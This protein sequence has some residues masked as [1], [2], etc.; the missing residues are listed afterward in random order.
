MSL[1]DGRV[2]QLL[3]SSGSKLPTLEVVIRDE[4]VAL[5]S[6]IP[7][8]L[9]SG[10]GLEKVVPGGI[11]LDRV[12]TIFGE[13]GSFKSTVKNAIVHAI[14]SA[15]H[16]VVDCSFEDSNAL[17]AARWISRDTGIPYGELAAR[18]RRLVDPQL[19]SAAAA[20][21]VIAAGDMAPTMDEVV[22]V[23]RQYKRIAGAKAVVV[24][25]I[26]LLEGQNQKEMLDDVMRRAQILAKR[27]QMAVILV[28]QVKQDIGT[29]Y[30]RREKRPVIHDCLGS[31]AIRTATKLGIGV[32]RPFNYCKAPVDDEGP[33]GLYT[34]MR[35]NW[36]EGMEQ[37]DAIYPEFL[38]L[39]IAKSV[40]GVC[41]A[42]VYCRV[43][44][45]TGVVTPFDPSR[46]L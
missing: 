3:S 32:F 5:R 13:S 33:Y 40:A 22:R 4:L 36:P 18:Q 31:S 19:P 39:I 16:V 27:E 11:P 14:A 23:A 34:R 26:Q 35:E 46:F 10:V 45:K 15:G 21:R 42:T 7:V 37:F 17:T 9:P 25:Y 20:G 28:S 41:P 8:G 2:N 43:N 38:E 6:P 30:E 44:P 24:D 12:T 29:N 1:L